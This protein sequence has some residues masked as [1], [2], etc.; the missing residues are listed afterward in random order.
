MVAPEFTKDERRKLTYFYRLVM[1]YSDFKHA[2]RCA[3]YSLAQ[4]S[5]LEENGGDDLILRALYCSMV[6]SYSRP[7]NSSGKS[8]VGN[9]PPLTNELE[10]LLSKEEL[11]IHKYL[12]RCRNKYLAHSDAKAINPEPFVA[13]DLPG[14]L[15]IPSKIDALAPFTKEYTESV[16]KLLKKVYHWSV[17]ERYR[18]EPEIKAWL[19]IETWNSENADIVT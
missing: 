5:E 11:G 16:L 19:P 2:Y 7:F 18:I 9:I 3:Q 12:R 10:A 4:H 8:N 15:V 6:V 1:S 14:E 17:E 13:T